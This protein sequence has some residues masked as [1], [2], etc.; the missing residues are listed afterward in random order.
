MGLACTSR[1]L[2]TLTLY[3]LLCA[4]AS[5]PCAA[6]AAASHHAGGRLEPLPLDDSPAQRLF[7][8]L[9]AEEPLEAQDLRQLIARL[10]CGGCPRCV[11]R[12][13]ACL[14]AGFWAPAFGDPRRPWACRCRCRCSGSCR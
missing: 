5:R 13:R 7:G 12:V 6:A 14:I 4:V 11:A 3:L 10:R 1:L 9:G 2:L 8:V